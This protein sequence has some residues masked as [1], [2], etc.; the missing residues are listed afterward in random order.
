MEV[1]AYAGG[2]DHI[3]IQLEN[4]NYQDYQ[5]NRTPNKYIENTTL[6]RNVL[7]DSVKVL[8]WSCSCRLVTTSASLVI[9]LANTFAIMNEPDEVCDSVADSQKSLNCLLV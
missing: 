6:D 1:G 5:Q 8:N 9:D 2:S 7:H 3:L 4:P